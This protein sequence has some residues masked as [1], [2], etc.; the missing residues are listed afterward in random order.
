MDS[1]FS[2]VKSTLSARNILVVDDDPDVRA[3]MALALRRKGFNVT[4]ACDPAEARALAQPHHHFDLLV[5]DFQMPGMSG[6]ELYKHLVS[7]RPELL[8]LFVTGAMA[9][10]E[11]ALN[12]L[13]AVPRLRKPFSVLEFLTHVR[14]ILRTTVPDPAC[15]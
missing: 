11:L 15:V 10:L 5:T 8:V 2:G 7:A 12:E 1:A 13:Q 6:V 4:V 14:A 9:E 3:L